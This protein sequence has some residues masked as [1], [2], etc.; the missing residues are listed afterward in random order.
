MNTPYNLFA[1]IDA[2]AVGIPAQEADVTIVG[3]LNV[4]Y[5]IAGMV[6]VFAIIVA[7]FMMVVQ[8]NSPEKI[9]KRKKAITFAVVGLAVILLA[10]TITNW[11]VGRF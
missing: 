8:G 10:F 3:V 5:F 11:L 7:G 2:S 4:V 1:K 9:A 6:A